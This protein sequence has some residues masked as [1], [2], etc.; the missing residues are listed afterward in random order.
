MEQREKE[1]SRFP[2]KLQYE[3]K[4]REGGNLLG[5]NVAVCPSQRIALRKMG[6][7]VVILWPPLH[8]AGRMTSDVDY[9]YKRIGFHYVRAHS[10]YGK[11]QSFGEPE[12][13]AGKPNWNFHT[14]ELGNATGSGDTEIPD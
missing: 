11:S 2:A 5:G 10:Y 6:R 9:R 1:G 13:Q 7:F 12:E 14:E 8:R 4:R 3:R